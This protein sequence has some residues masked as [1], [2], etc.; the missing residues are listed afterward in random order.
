MLAYRHAFVAGLWAV[1]I[2]V[3]SLVASPASANRAASAPLFAVRST[4][5]GKAVLPQRIHWI[6][7]PEHAPSKIKEVDFLID[8]R[9]G[10]IEHTAPYVYA[11]D[12]NWL[13]TSFLAPGKHRFTTRV[14]AAVGGKAVE[15]VTARVLARTAPP[16]ELAGRWQRTMTAADAQKATSSQPPPPGLWKI[17]ISAKGWAM[18]DPQGGG[19]LFDVAYLGPRTL[20]MRPTIE[21]P[22]FP[23]PANGGFCDSTDPLSRWKFTVAADRKSVVLD[24]IGHDP[25]GDRT[26]ILQGTWTKIS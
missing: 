15:T 4:L 23:N 1:V 17:R 22:P 20:Q 7:K 19:G 3:A 16:V 12:G 11:N 21:V 14:I 2:V 6:A 13:V 5:D 25:C 18:T 26:A 10:W 9:L 24:P 8:G